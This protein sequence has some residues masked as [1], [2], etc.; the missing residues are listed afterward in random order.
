MVVWKPDKKCIFYD[1]KCLESEWSKLFENQ[2]KSFRKVKCNHSNLEVCFTSELHW[3]AL[4]TSKEL[5]FLIFLF[6]S[7]SALLWDFS[8]CQDRLRGDASEFG[9]DLLGWALYMWLLSR[10]S[11]VHWDWGRTIGVCRLHCSRILLIVHVKATIRLSLSLPSHSSLCRD[12]NLDG[13]DY[14]LTN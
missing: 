11:I 9:T 12:S 10:I 8:L 13:P 2:T 4:L 7:C 6:S 5:F 1:L 14:G 3:P